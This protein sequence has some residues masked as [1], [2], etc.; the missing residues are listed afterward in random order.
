MVVHDACGV[1]DVLNGILCLHIFE[2]RRRRHT[3]IPGQLRHDVGFDVLI[4]GGGAGHHD[5]RGHACF[6]FADA[7]EDALAL[8][9]RGGAVGAGGI[10]EDDEG[11]EVGGGSVAR[12]ERE[13]DA[14]RE[15]DNGEDGCGE[16]EEGAVE[17]LHGVRVSGDGLLDKNFDAGDGLEDFVA[18]VVTALQGMRV[19]EAEPHLACRVLPG[20]G[21]EGKIDCG[22]GSGEHD[23][24]AA[25][26][27]SEDEEL[28]WRHGEADFCGF[29]AVVD[30]SEDG[31]DFCTEDGFEAVEGFGDGVGA[32]VSDDA[33]GGGHLRPPWGGVYQACDSGE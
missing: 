11:V 22:E 4:V 21:L 12:G 15:E 13:I 10:A 31:N 29:S 18:E 3:L 6:I 8:L 24:S 17:N 19:V 7:F 5:G 28:G 20:E 23:G 26:G 30:A 25:F 32:G 9:G 2:N 27:I 16:I 1:V 33:V 14:C